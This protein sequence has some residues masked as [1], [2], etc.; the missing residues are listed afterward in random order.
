[1]REHDRTSLLTVVRKVQPI[2]E[3]CGHEEEFEKGVSELGI[4]SSVVSVRRVKKGHLCSEE[5]LLRKED[6]SFA[7]V[8]KL[9]EACKHRRCKGLIP[10]E[11][12]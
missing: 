5:K 10:Q 3:I 9:A 1:M 7:P 6:D 4:W 11:C 8:L 2:K 12:L